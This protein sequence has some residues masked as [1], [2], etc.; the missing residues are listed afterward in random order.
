MGI[1]KLDAV[2]H[3]SIPVNDLEEA[4]KFYGEILGLEHVGRLANSPMSCFKLGNHNILLCQRK[5]PLVG[6]SSKMAGCIMPS[7]S[8]PRC[9]TRLASFST[10]WH[11]DSRAGGLPARRFFYR[12]AALRS[13]SERQSHRT[14]RRELEAGHA[15]ADL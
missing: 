11:Q 13:R 1:L 6:R 14:A 9:L 4:E 15:D 8:A 3:W 10:G 5:D 7:T 2:V 12:P